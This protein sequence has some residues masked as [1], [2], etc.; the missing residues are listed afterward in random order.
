MT[1]IVVAWEQKESFEQDRLGRMGFQGLR[2][3]V[4]GVLG[5]LCG[6]AWFA[7]SHQIVSHATQ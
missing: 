4:D 1:V 2:Y 6:F 3:G 5:A 7:D